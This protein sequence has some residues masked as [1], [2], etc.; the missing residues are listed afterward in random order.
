[1]R[2]VADLQGIVADWMER[3]GLVPSMMANATEKDKDVSYFGS[4]SFHPA[5]IRD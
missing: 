1:M 2:Y 4:S 5:V 3:S